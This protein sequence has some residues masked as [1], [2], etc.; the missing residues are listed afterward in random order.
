MGLRAN[1]HLCFWWFQYI[2]LQGYLS[3]HK[4]W[5]TTPLSHLL[6]GYA[7]ISFSIRVIQ[8]WI[9]WL[10]EWFL[11]C[12]IHQLIAKAVKRHNC[13]H[14]CVIHHNHCL[15]NHHQQHHWYHHRHHH[16]ILSIIFKHNHLRK[17]DWSKQTAHKNANWWPQTLWI[18]IFF[19]WLIFFIYCTINES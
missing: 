8:R 14:I 5:P 10:M 18:N 13:I 6:L 2:C 15:Y 16:T 12:R 4:T 9:G 11:S 19:L 7:G 17:L 1:W 3:G